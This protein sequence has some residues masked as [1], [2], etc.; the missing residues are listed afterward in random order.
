MYISATLGSPHDAHLKAVIRGCQCGFEML[1]AR[2]V[3]ETQ[4]SIPPVCSTVK[5]RKGPRRL[6][7]AGLEVAYAAVISQLRKSSEHPASTGTKE[8]V[9]M[10][11]QV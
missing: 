7:E 1:G 8:I 2:P 4:Q 10:L 9:S 11:R 3:A 6:I 5:P